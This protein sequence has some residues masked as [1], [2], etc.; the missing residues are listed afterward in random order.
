M[1]TRTQSQ[2]YN[3]LA[4]IMAACTT[5]GTSWK[6]WLKPVITWQRMSPDLHTWWIDSQESWWITCSMEKVDNGG[7]EHR[8]GISI[9]L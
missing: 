9:K 8:A 6:Q 1:S 2:P 3:H 4:Q 7:L 5:P